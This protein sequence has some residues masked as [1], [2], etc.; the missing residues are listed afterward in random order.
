MRL[1]KLLESFVAQGR[2]T[3]GSPQSNAVDVDIWKAGKAA[4]QPVTVKA[5]K[6]KTT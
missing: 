5:K 2:S 6:K 3:P 4:H 1:T